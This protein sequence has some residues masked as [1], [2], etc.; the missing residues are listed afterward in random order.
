VI[1][2]LA[3]IEL[4]LASSRA[5]RF[6]CQLGNFIEMEIHPVYVKGSPPWGLTIGSGWARR[7]WEEEL[8]RKGKE[9]VA[10]MLASEIDF[11]PVLKEPRVV[12][13]DRDAELLKILEKEAFDL[14]VEGAYFDWT[15]AG[16]YQKIQSRI[17]QA[18][19][20]P[21]ALARVLMKIFELLLLC[22]DREGTQTLVR[23]FQRLWAGCAVPI[24]LAVP[25]GAGE[26][27]R[28]EVARA[29]EVLT[30]AHLK[31]TVQEEFPF[32]PAPPEDGFLRQYGLVGLALP[33]GIKKDSAEINW[34]TQV[35]APLLLVLY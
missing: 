14:Y 6:A 10:E 19:R 11:C 25:A 15:P 21:L 32:F 13:G 30:V 4:D 3:A 2:A 22:L 27:L 34:L 12:F 1:K 29:Q 5:M 20:G 26:E 8:V 7:H 23:N 28:D 35:K 16:L 31:V 18:A 17:F 33:R 24:S 9:E